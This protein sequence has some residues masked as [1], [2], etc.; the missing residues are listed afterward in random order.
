MG[1]TSDASDGHRHC[2]HE[3]ATGDRREYISPD[4]YG[5]PVR[6]TAQLQWCVCGAA[7]AIGVVEV[8]G[9]THTAMGP[10]SRKTP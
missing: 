5:E 2:P 10:W 1:N 3:P 9:Y 7:R 6:L 8:G 4:G